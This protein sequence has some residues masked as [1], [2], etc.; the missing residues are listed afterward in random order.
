MDPM[1]DRARRRGWIAPCLRKRGDVVSTGPYHGPRSHRARIAKFL[2]IDDLKGV[3]GARA[4]LN[5]KLKVRRTISSDPR[6][7]TRDMR[8]REVL[9]LRGFFEFD[10]SGVIDLQN[11]VFIFAI[12]NLLSRPARTRACKCDHEGDNQRR[13]SSC[14]NHQ[15]PRGTVEYRAAREVEQS[16]NTCAVRLNIGFYIEIMP[17]MRSEPGEEL[18][19]R[20]SH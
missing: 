10:D 1:D 12:R 6:H 9:V 8:S 2:V 20:L 16:N 17:Q 4:D 14:V 7:F 15:S 3:L 5:L 13:V 18:R 19:Q 11:L